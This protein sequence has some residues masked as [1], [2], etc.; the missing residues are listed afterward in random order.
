MRATSGLV[1]VIIATYNRKE[2]LAR[3]VD[4][5]LKST[6]PKIEILIA[7]DPSQNMAKSIVMKK[8]SRHKNIR[9]MENAKRI[10]K[11]ASL[12]KMIKASRGEFLLHFDD[13]N[14]IDREC[15]SELVST[16]RKFPEA[17]VVEALAFYY[18]HPSIIMHA[19]TDRSGF[20]RG[21]VTQFSNEKWKGQFEEGHE[22][23]NADNA[24]MIR[25]SAIKA[26]GMFDLMSCYGEGAELQARIRKAGYR[27]LINPKAKTYHDRPY[28][29]GAQSRELFFER[30]GRE[31]IYYVMLSKILYE[32]S[33]ETT[34]QKL[35]FLISLPAYLGFYLRGIALDKRKKPGEKLVLAGLLLSGTMKGLI[36][37]A[38]GKRRI[39]RLREIGT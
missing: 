30:L 23:G 17:G 24:Y 12:N 14:V 1:S 25:R 3:C 28:M 13:D 5:V 6:Y 19:G 10:F 22:I 36:A 29:P 26:A 16:M 27:I 15:I 37:A 9:Y 35:T 11:P 21:A 8:Y 7:E 32:F 4:S 31:A 33:Y 39:E 20:M 2:I 34:V 38:L 18:S